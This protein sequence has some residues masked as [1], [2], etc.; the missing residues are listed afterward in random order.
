MV[1][2]KNRKKGIGT[3]I[4]NICNS[5]AK[6]I[7]ITIS[8]GLINTDKLLRFY[9]KLGFQIVKEDECNYRLQPFSN[10]VKN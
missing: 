6:N 5:K 2:P 9:F 4:I 7:N 8:K 3:K 10:L 1:D